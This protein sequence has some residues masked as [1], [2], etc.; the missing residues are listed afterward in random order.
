[1]PQLL[2]TLQRNLE[3]NGVIVHRA[4]T[5]AD[6]ASYITGVVLRHGREVV[7][8]KSMAAEEIGL[9]ERLQ[10]AGIDVVETDLG[11]FIV[12]TAGEA[13]EH[14]VLVETPVA[15]VEGVSGFPEMM[16][17]EKALIDQELHAT[18]DGITNGNAKS[19]AP[20]TVSLVRALVCTGSVSVQA[21]IV[22]ASES[23]MNLAGTRVSPTLSLNPLVG[24]NTCPVG[25]PPGTETTSGTWLTGQ[26][27]NSYVF[28]NS[29]R[30]W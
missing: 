13:P 28:M 15:E 16:A 6:A 12:Q 3:A 26:I 29:R 21:V 27:K 24:L 7:K 10:A 23:K 1:M 18:R 2:D 19:P 5:G 30:R 4:A 14:I 25:A 9:N 22:P 8:G 17:A 11:E 20:G